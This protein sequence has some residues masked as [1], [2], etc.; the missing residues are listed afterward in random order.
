VV[1]YGLGVCPSEMLETQDFPLTDQA[2]RGP[3]F[4]SA[5]LENL[6]QNQ[7]AEWGN[8]LS[9][10]WF[11]LWG[12]GWEHWMADATPRL[13]AERFGTLKCQADIHA[14]FGRRSQGSLGILVRE[15]GLRAGTEQMARGFRVS[16]PIR[17]PKKFEMDADFC[18]EEVHCWP[19]AQHIIICAFFRHPCWEG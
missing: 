2:S 9:D 3:L 11:P 1:V 12:L 7:D 15:V 16:S 18:F 5:E 19:L 8:T 6:S 13:W 14:A 17:A 4:C 10:Q